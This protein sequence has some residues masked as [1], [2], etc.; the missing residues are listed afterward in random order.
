[1]SAPK[2]CPW[3]IAD[4]GASIVPNSVRYK[5]VGDPWASYKPELADRAGTVTTGRLSFRVDATA[6]MRYQGVVV[7]VSKSFTV[8]TGVAVT[9]GARGTRGR[10]HGL[11]SPGRISSMTSRTAWGW[12]LA[13]VHSSGQILDTWYPDPRLGAT[14]ESAALDFLPTLP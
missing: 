7:P 5:L 1:M 3:S 12:G 13:S 9:L 8:T 11:N 10:L 4:A 2:N 6:S 14:D